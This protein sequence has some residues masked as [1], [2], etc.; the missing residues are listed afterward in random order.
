MDGQLEDTS[1]PREENRRLGIME[2]DAST[3]LPLDTFLVPFHYSGVLK[4]VMIPHGKP[5][6]IPP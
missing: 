1:G 2:I 4:H 3:K 6:R 5:M